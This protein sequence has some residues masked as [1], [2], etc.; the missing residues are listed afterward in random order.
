M[1]L[2]RH[3]PHIGYREVVGP[4]NGV[5]RLLRFGT[6]T[7]PA[8]EAFTAET[9][10]DEAVLV[11]LSGRA[12]VQVDGWT[13]S[14]LSRQ[15]VFTER[16]TAVYVPRATQYT[17]HN[18]GD[19]VLELAV[20]RTPAPVRYEPFLVTPQDV[21]AR[22]V[23]RDN[24]RRSVHDIVV[25]NAEGRVHR[26]IV[27][28]TFNPPGNWSSYPP[29]KHDTY[30]PGVEACMEEV[31]YYRL[32]PRQG[33]G[34]QHIYTA[35]RSLDEAH[36]VRHGDVFLIPHGY[37]PVCAAGGYELYYLWLMAGETDRVMI[38]HDDP[39]HAWVKQV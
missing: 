15:D 29:H 27:G 7:L 10:E 25:A 12:N 24:W 11:L 1:L 19:G 31:Y 2:I 20:C 32:R 16:A 8:G 33:F 35:D 18:E 34:L 22:E 13:F 39:A 21:Q 26:I 23:G 30:Q 4:D 37:H 17:V 6:L 3:V 28:E 14:G 36:A 5:L 9:G 38:P